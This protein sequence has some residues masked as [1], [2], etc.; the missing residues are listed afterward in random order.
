LNKIFLK[1]NNAPGLS[2][3]SFGENKTGPPTDY[4]SVNEP[5]YL[6]LTCPNGVLLKNFEGF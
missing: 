6:N 3:N 5:V 1:F 4:A 2:W